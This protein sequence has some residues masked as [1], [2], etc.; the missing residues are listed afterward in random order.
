MTSTHVDAG[1][2]QLLGFSVKKEADSKGVAGLGALVVGLGGASAEGVATRGEGSGGVVDSVS[3]RIVV[4][5]ERASVVVVSSGK[6]VGKEGTVSGWERTQ[7]T[8][9][10]VLASMVSNHVEIRKDGLGGMFQLILS[11]V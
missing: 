6:I 9:K 2:E 1:L 3:S 8:V 4:V 5:V 10:I 11:K 7:R